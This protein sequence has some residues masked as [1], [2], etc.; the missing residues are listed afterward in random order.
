[1]TLPPFGPLPLYWPLNVNVAVALVHIADVELVLH[2]C[3]AK[4]ELVPALDPGHVV[5]KCQRVVVEVRKRVGAAANRE[6]AFGELQACFR[7]LVEV[8]AK[9]RLH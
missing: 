7:S 5:V 1:M 3:A 8:D 9:R 6:L 4:V 2:P